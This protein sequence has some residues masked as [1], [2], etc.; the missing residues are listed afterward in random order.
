MDT[1]EVGTRGGRRRRRHSVEFKAQVIEACRQPGISIAGVALANGLN[2]NM[3]RKWVIDADQAGP[4]MSVSR[5]EPGSTA[6]TVPGFIAV[7]RPAA[8]EVMPAEIRIEVQRAGTAIKIE[9]PLTAAAECAA[10]LR[11]ALR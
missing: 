5:V 8:A 7:S 10:W 11:D 1:I 2:A 9:W 3:L 4:E 6:A